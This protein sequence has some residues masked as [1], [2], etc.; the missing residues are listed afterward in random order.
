MPEEK[1]EKIE[2]S[3]I[4][5]YNAIPEEVL[6]KSKRVSAQIPQKLFK[7]GGIACIFFGVYIFW[8]DIAE[9]LLYTLPEYA[10]IRVLRELSYYLPQ[11]AI[12]IVL[13][14]VG[15]KLI[16][17]KKKELDLNNDDEDIYIGKDTSEIN[18]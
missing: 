7:V 10:A 1:F 17:H 5:F 18:K 12:S 3:F 6:P 13:I 14:V 11:I 9:N 16:A 8:E 2:D 4:F 15:I